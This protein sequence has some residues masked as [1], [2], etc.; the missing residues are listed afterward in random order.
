MTKN[1]RRPSPCVSLQVINDLPKLFTVRHRLALGHHVLFHSGHDLRPVPRGVCR[2]GGKCM[3]L[4]AVMP[5]QPRFFRLWLRKRLIVGAGGHLPHH[6]TLHHPT[7]HHVATGTRLVTAR[8]QGSPSDHNER[9][10]NH[11]LGHPTSIFPCTDA[12]PH[13]DTLRSRKALLIT[14]T[15]LKLMAAAAMIGDS[16]RPKNG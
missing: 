2:R 13:N 3:A 12:H 5:K 9:N 11:P 4:T 8:Q 10:R 14:D 16:N 6:A 15:E 7:P 1:P